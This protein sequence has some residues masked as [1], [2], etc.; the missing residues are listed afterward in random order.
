MAKSILTPDQQLLLAAILENEEI[1]EQFYLTG[2]TALAEFYF[3]HRLSEG[4]DFFSEKP[5]EESILLKWASNTAKK[6]RISNVEYTF[7]LSLSEEEVAK[8]F[9]GVIESIDQPKFLGDAKWSLVEQFFLDYAQE[10]SKK[11]YE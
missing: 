9:M 5:F 8:H 2:G 1:V 6:L 7:D 10:L 11:T 3:Q 4:F